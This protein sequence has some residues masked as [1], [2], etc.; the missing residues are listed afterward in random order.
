VLSG[1][2]AGLGGRR[3][4]SG[5][6]ATGAGRAPTR[7]A[8][9]PVRPPPAAPARPHPP[10]RARWGLAACA[11]RPRQERQ[12]PSGARPVT[13]AMSRN[14]GRRGDRGKRGCRRGLPRPP[15]CSDYLILPSSCNCCVL[16]RACMP[17]QCATYAPQPCLAKGRKAPPA[18]STPRA[19][20]ARAR[21]Q[22]HRQ[23]AMG[24]RGRVPAPR[25][26]APPRLMRAPVTGFRPA[27]HR[28]VSR[29]M[30]SSRVSRATGPAPALPSASA[31]SMSARF[32]SCGRGRRRGR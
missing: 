31:A 7:R 16:H 13:R 18:L 15:P 22:H 17:L 30:R 12:E 21:A 28:L 9:R 2:G 10:R 29:Y 14:V 6:G 1:A 4:G 23:A 20:R 32:S 3:G 25:P 8:R 5:S 26:A 24:V 11:R 19:R 27:R